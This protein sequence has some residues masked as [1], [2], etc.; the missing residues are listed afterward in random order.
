MK[1][2]YFLT[3]D[4]EEIDFLANNLNLDPRDLY[5]LGF[6]KGFDRATLKKWNEK[7][8]MDF[9]VSYR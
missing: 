4:E 6:M 3:E 1:Q 7:G 5:I 8:L 9:S 2:K